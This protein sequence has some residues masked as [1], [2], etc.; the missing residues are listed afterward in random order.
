METEVASLPTKP[1]SI[2]GDRLLLFLDI[3][4]SLSFLGRTKAMPTMGWGGQ[5]SKAA[6]L[7]LLWDKLGIKEGHEDTFAEFYN[8]TVAA[9][10]DFLRSNATRV[11][12]IEFDGFFVLNRMGILRPDACEPP[13]YGYYMVAIFT[14]VA[15]GK[16]TH[17]DFE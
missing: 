4:Q 12:N 3:A 16:Y 1:F 15:V 7:R 6:M 2:R 11:G 13:T 17:K 9:L 14:N 10:R 5:F 8:D